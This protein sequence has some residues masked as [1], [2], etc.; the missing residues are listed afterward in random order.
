M[1]IN[2][3]SKYYKNTDDERI[4]VRVLNH[5][6]ETKTCK[7]WNIN[8]GKNEIIDDE[9][10]NSEYIELTP[11]MKLNAMITKDEDGTKD[12][13]VWVYRLDMIAGGS[14]E[15]IVM[16]RANVYSYFKNLS[17]E[18]NDVWVGECLNYIDNP[19]QKSLLDLAEFKDV[20]EAQT[21]SLYIT[22]DASDILMCLGKKFVSKTDNVLNEMSNTFAKTP[23]I[24]GYVRSLDLLMDVNDFIGEVQMVFNIYRVPWKVV[25]DEDSYNS[26][27][28]II[29]N[30]KQKKALE[31]VLRKHITDIK[32]IPYDKD[33]DISKIIQYEHVMISD[34][35]NIIYLIAYKKLSDYPIED[36]IAV[37]MGVK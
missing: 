12:V 33:V 30:D 5:R 2:I 20:E 28:D 23:N 21:M 11:E 4:V 7:C 26:D 9:T 22:D 18:G 24:K 34:L 25:L 32:I 1:A 16:L 27:G 10:L 14:I 37:G 36:D 8:T 31:D 17:A 29:L 13:Y 15:P 6:E 35:S 3:G 19:E